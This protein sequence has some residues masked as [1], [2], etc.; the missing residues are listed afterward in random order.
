ML[1][2]GV[3]GVILLLMTGALVVVSAVHASTRARTAADQ[4]ALAG[5]A[6]L[7]RGQGDPCDAAA[8][9]ARVNR[10][11]LIDC[12]IAGDAVTV[13]VVVPATVTA[14]WGLGSAHARSRAGPDPGAGS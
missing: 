5:A 4:A 14:R 6:A 11:T 12:S 2:V 1:L 7:L 10:A 9:L 13:N 3:M 8:G